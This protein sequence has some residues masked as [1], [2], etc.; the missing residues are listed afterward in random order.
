[1]GEENDARTQNVIKVLK[2]RLLYVLLMVVENDAFIKAVRRKLK[3]APLCVLHMEE[4]YDAL[5]QSARRALKEAP[6]YVLHMA[7]ENDV[8]IVSHGLTLEVVD[9]NMMVIVLPVSSTSF[10]R[11]HEA[12]SCMLIPKRYVFVMRSMNSLKGSSMIDHYT[13]GIATVP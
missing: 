4:A 12:R 10:Q 1:M 7:E 2:G 6:L 11:T 9:G 3:E 8:P 13:Q 5:I